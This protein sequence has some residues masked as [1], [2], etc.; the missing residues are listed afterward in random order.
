MAYDK[1]PQSR[2]EE[3]LLSMINKT[4]YDK[5]PQSREE[6]LLLELKDAI[7][8]GGDSQHH[9]S[10]DEQVV[11]TWIDSK[12]LYEKTLTY[13]QAYTYSNSGWGEIPFTGVPSDIETAI[14][15]DIIGGDDD[16]MQF[17]D[18]R[19]RYMVDLSGSSPKIVAYSTQANQS[20]T[21]ITAIIRYIK[22]TN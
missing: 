7:E 1:T 9:Y 15:L 16:G 12:T 22:T 4:E 21:W 19:V 11:G 20:V 6:E 13:N 18:N 8:Q 14:S 10:T 3:I 5:T 2:N 17:N